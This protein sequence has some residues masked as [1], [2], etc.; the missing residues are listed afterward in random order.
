MTIKITHVGQELWY[1]PDY[2]TSRSKTVASIGRK[3]AVLDGLRNRVEIAT[4]IVDGG[5][6]SPPGTLY[7]SEAD[8]KKHLEHQTAA[9]RLSNRI[10]RYAL[11]NVSIEKI[12]AAAA[13]LGISLAAV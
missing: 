12:I 4:G 1:V 2:G 6:Y 7:N 3:W 9:Q 13:L 10:N 5:Q 11:R 8:Y